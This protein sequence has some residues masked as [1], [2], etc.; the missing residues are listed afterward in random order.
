MNGADYQGQY[1]LGHQLIDSLSISPI[2]AYMLLR[3]LLDGCGGR[4]NKVSRAKKCIKLGVEELEK[5]EKS[6][7]FSQAVQESLEAKEHRRPRTLQEIRTI[8]NRLIRLCPELKKKRVRCITADDCRKWLD[9]C[10]NTPRQWNKGRIIL[11]GILGY[12]HKRGWCDR[13]VVESL[14][15]PHIKERRILP[16]TLEETRQLLKSAGTLYEGA[17]LP[18]CALML[19]AGLRPKETHRLTWNCI[20]LQ[21]GIVNIEPHHSK[22]GGCRQVEIRPIL[23]KLLLPYAHRKPPLSSVCPPNWVKKW[24]AVRMDSGLIKEMGW[25]QDVLRHTYASYHHA[26]FKDRKMLEREMGHSNSSLLNT[27]YIDMSRITPCKGRKFWEGGRL[28][29]HINKR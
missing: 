11:S 29:L 13:N 9:R 14:P 10:F 19:Y 8:A 2:D 24:R 22:T 3:E 16:L 5:A 20:N 12:S 21:E 26:Y 15:K 28:P 18:A 27:R 7:A 1:Q 25:I 6:V 17:C 4:G 23:K